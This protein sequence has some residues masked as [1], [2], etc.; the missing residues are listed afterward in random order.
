MDERGPLTPG[1]RPLLGPRFEAAPWFRGDETRNAP[2]RLGAAAFGP[3]A[4]ARHAPD[5][6]HPT[7]AEQRRPL[8]WFTDGMGIRDTL[9]LAK[10]AMSPEAIKQGLSASTTPPTPE[11]MQAT[12]DSLPPEP[13][14]ELEANLAL[15]KA[16]RE[17]ALAQSEAHRV[18][19]GPAGNFLYG[20]SAAE[21]LASLETESLGGML[22]MTAQQ[23]G[24]ELKGAYTPPPKHEK[25]RDL[26]AGIGGQ[27]RAARDAARAPY[28]APDRW[29]VSISR[30]ATRGR[31]QVDEV[32]AFLRTSGLAARPE[33]VYGVYRVPDRI[34]P[35][36]TPSSEAGRVVEW[37]IVHSG[38][39][40]APV[41]VPVV[42]GY[43]DALHQWVARRRGEPS[44]LDEDLG[45]A[46]L[47]RAGIGAE[48]CLGIARLCTFVEPKDRWFAVNN[49]GG[50]TD[51]GYPVI[52]IVDGVLVFHVGESTPIVD[53]IRAEAPIALG[54]D[55]L[56]GTHTE[57]LNWKEI[58]RA[59][60]QRLQHPPPTPSP[61]PY[62]PS[63]P[64]E[65]L[66]AY[67]EIV[68]VRSFDCYSAQVTIDQPFPLVGR[69][70]MGTSNI[71]SAQPCADGKERR[72][73]QG[74]RRAVITYRDRPEYAEGRT[75]WHR[76]Q[77]EVLS[78]H[79]ERGMELRRPVTPDD[80]PDNPVLRAGAKMLNLA[81]RVSSIGE[82][83]SPPPYRYCWPVVG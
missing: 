47:G 76:Y 44:V 11:E 40:E 15:A 50:E 45:V 79:L 58:A 29:P 61:Y 48:H 14:A 60:H 74:A 49:S 25:D 46:Y 9:R 12:L 65:L 4:A 2:N 68:G 5:Q 33:L 7:L 54:A 78:A 42:A 77:N 35:A 71:G 8:R 28:L 3:R 82:W 13:R 20:P 53:Q 64:Q 21:Q 31:T 22:K 72:R 67:L 51:D 32:L 23:F 6:R 36:I 17:Q 16:A 75:R 66:R 52:P 38:L 70:L 27:E 39:P 34:S 41:E 83:E 73:L 37:D 30:I 57:V 18:L 69:I 55:A 19:D 43:F 24:K 56:A 81:E 1:S 10:Q 62:L 63:A 80:L 26:A 59:V